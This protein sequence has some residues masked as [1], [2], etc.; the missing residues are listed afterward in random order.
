MTRPISLITGAGRGIGRGIAIELAKLGHAIIINYAGNAS[1]ADECL[2]LVREAG[3]EGTDADLFFLA[4]K[5]A[6][7]SGPRPQ[8]FLACGTED[9]VKFNDI[10]SGNAADRAVND[11]YPRK[12]AH[13]G[14]N[15]PL[16]R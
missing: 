13:P 8:L 9:H 4:E 6:A 16:A 7:S 15:G 10:L 14:Q 5:V 2:Q 12:S 3:G 1:A 11:A